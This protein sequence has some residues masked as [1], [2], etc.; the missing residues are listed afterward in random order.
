M[1]IPCNGELHCIERETMGQNILNNKENKSNETLNVVLARINI[2]LDCVA[3]DMVY[4][5]DCLH[6]PYSWRAL[7][8]RNYVT[9]YLH[10]GQKRNLKMEHCETLPD[11][12][13]RNDI[14]P[15]WSAS[16][17]LLVHCKAQ[18]GHQ[19][20]QNSGIG[21]PLLRRPP[22]YYNAL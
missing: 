11:N 10:L 13:R 2:P 20:K 4:H 6:E 8:I 16:N 22:T 3:F 18:C 14:M 5:W 7:S 19:Q 9:I 17:S 21:A 15:T 1:C 12:I